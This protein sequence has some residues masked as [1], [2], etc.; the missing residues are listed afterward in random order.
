[1]VDSLQREL[2]M[3]ITSLQNSR[4]KGV[5]KLRKRSNRDAQDLILVEGYREVQRAL[6]NAYQPVSLFYCPEQYLGKNEET[7]VIACKEAG[8]SLFE[9][10]PHVFSKIAYKDRPEGLLGL[11]YQ[12]HLL[13]SSIDLPKNPL[14]LIV[15]SIEKPGN[16]GAILRSA[17]GAGVDAVVVCDKCT[18]MYN[19]NTVR[20]SIGTLFSLPIV[21]ASSDETLRWLQGKKVRCVAAS[22]HAKELYTGM[23][24]KGGTAIVVGTEKFGLSER[25]MRQADLLVRIPMLGQVDSLN[26][27][28]ATTILLYE[29]VRQRQSG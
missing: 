4:I 11:F 14:I 25:W 23:D 24:M 26:V 27:A 18:D 1:M 13:L 9:C 20:A 10:S 19:P 7:V 29:A 17:D 2:Y 8:A 22:P 3:P 15:E 12:R 28:S 16:L 21:E 5:V 6:D